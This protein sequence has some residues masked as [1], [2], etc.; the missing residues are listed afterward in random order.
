[1]KKAA[2][3]FYTDGKKVLLLK[4]KSGKNKN[5]WGLPGGGIEEGETSK[6]AAKRESK[7]EIGV[8]RGKKF[9]ESREFYKN[10][11]WTTYFHKIKTTFSCKLSE[12]HTKWK[13]YNFE[14]L[15]NLKIHPSLK[16]NLEKYLNIVNKE[17]GNSIKENSE[18]SF[19]KWLENKIDCRPP[20]D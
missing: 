13:W 15:H 11:H 10:L 4:K 16:K 9:N 7:E 1:M 20:I 19:S 18:Y 5:T 17:F 14:D 2:G 3:I 6:E 12:E 8:V